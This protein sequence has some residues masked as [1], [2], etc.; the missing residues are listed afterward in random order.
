MIIYSILQYYIM[1][2]KF[3]NYIWQEAYKKNTDNIIQLLD[4]D[5][6]AIVLDIGCGD[7]QK[8]SLFKKKIGCKKIVGIDGVSKRLKAA[9][10][11]GIEVK[12]TNLEKKWPLFN[13]YFDVIISNQVIE[14]IVD[15]DLFISEIYRVL[16]PNGYCVIST[17]NLS[18]WHNIFG[19][20]LGHQDFSHHL[21]KKSHVGNPLSPHFGE[22]TVAWSA[23]DNSGV[24]DTA[25]PHIKIMTYLSLIKVFKAYQLKFEKGLGSGLGV[26]Y[27]SASE[28]E[29]VREDVRIERTDPDVRK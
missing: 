19:L 12:L 5:H 13:N 1:F 8:S 16:K 21:I 28:G 23:K 20:I 26:R 2:F 6:D 25:F 17:E 24:D 11:R 29:R 9:R 14:H 22:K 18:S 4:K 7:G 27:D 15:L 3:L 10:K